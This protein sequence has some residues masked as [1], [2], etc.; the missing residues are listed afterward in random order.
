[1]PTH[2]VQASAASMGS[3]LEFGSYGICPLPPP[4][5]PSLLQSLYPHYGCRDAKLRFLLPPGAEVP[6][7]PHCMPA[8]AL[9]PEPACHPISKRPT[10]QG[11]CR[12]QGPPPA[13]VPAYKR[14]LHALHSTPRRPPA[15][16]VPREG[17]QTKG[18]DS[19]CRGASPRSCCSPEDDLCPACPE[20]PARILR[21][22]PMPP[23]A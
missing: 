3:P 7:G 15:T 13:G 8:Y 22:P 16:E 20:V 12:G 10:C 14:R 17:G 21:R 18:E 4:V 19:C 1:M 2:E 23:M 5:T 11:P 6:A 9:R